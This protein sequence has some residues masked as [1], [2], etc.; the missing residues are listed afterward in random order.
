VK[1]RRRY[2][3]R[4][5]PRPPAEPVPGQRELLAVREIVH[6]FLNADQPQEALQFAL[7]RVG[8]VV[9][10][11][12]G[13]VYLVDGASELMRLVAAHNWPER[14]R[15]WLSDVRVRVGFGPSGEAASERRVIEVPDVFADPDLEDWQDVAR[16][17]GFRALVALPLQVGTTALGAVAFYFRHW[18]DFTA[19]RRGLL[20]LVA[21]LMAAAAEKARLVDRLR[22]ADAAAVESHA[23]LERQYVA[24][25]AVRRAGRDFVE[26]AAAALRPALH[27]LGGDAAAQAQ[28]LVDDLVLAAEIADG[29][30]QVVVDAFDPRV[31]LREALRDAVPPDAPV[32]VIAEE[33][34]HELPPLR[35][36]R[37]KLTLLLARLVTRAIAAGRGAEA[38]VSVLVVDG[39]AEYRLPGS[40]G[41]DVAWIVAGAL[42]GLIG[43]TLEAGETD[44]M[45]TIAVSLP[46]EPRQRGGTSANRRDE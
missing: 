22:R 41:D 25:N 8:P 20:R 18:E 29:R 43:A 4:A 13:S 40:A 45:A 30:L 6:A 33:P 21:D 32:T 38:R 35:G 36:D 14:Y 23:E 5:T 1:P 46:L 19:E 34:G 31:P 3:V 24:V 39:R 11:T 27:A 15:P 42:A 17:L 26:R 10:A 16:E 2:V 28:A 12:L 9:G 37:E 7:D 44:G